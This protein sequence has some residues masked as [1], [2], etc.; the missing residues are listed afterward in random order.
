M[1]EVEI[2]ASV[3]SD[4][5]V[6]SFSSSNLALSILHTLGLK[7]V[8]TS[9]TSF[10]AKTGTKR[11]THERST[12]RKKI[13]H[14]FFNGW[15]CGLGPRY[16]P[17]CLVAQKSSPGPQPCR[18]VEHSTTVTTEGTK[19]WAAELLTL[20]MAKNRSKLQSLR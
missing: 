11:N 15:V 12:I 7:C 5:S 16:L 6:F 1:V 18:D 2:K 14:R 17:H 13:G 10:G 4:V 8:R 20:S 3:Y 9:H 19:P